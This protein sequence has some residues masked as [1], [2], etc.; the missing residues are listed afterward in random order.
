[1]IAVDA[2]LLAF[3]A[4]RGVPEHVRAARALEDLAMGA[5]PWALPWSAAEEFVAL[6]SHPHAV[7]RALDPGEAWA[8][9]DA[10]LASPTAHP[11]A[12]TERHARIAAEVLGLSGPDAARA[13]GFTTAVLLREHGVGELLSARRD[14]RRF[15]FLVV[16]DPIHGPAWSAGERPARRYRRL[17]A[18]PSHP[19]SRA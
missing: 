3:A 12:P 11:L 5:R 15:P 13:P 1:L 10:L 16:R 9:V 18:G 7:A 14:M 2:S 4:N 8:F 17:S 19:E 6:V